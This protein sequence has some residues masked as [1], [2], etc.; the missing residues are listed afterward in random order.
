MRCPACQVTFSLCAD[1][2]I[3]PRTGD[4]SVCNGCSAVM[5][6][7]RLLVPRIVSVDEVRRTL[8]QDGLV[9]VLSAQRAIMIT[10]GLKP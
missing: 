8:G 1:G 10:K 7:D 9:A 3:L 6:F 5:R 4:V 2:S